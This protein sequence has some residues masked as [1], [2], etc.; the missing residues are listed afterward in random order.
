[1]YEKQ[2]LISLETFS[3][4]KQAINLDSSCNIN[5]CA[6]NPCFSNGT[7]HSK[8]PSKNYTCSCLEQYTGSRCESNLNSDATIALSRD[9]ENNNMSTTDLWPLAIVFG[10]VFSLMLVFIIIWFLW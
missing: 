1:M 4:T 10:Y 8:L 7:C 5:P 6:S 2:L 3:C 9:N